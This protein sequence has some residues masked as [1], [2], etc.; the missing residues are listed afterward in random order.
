MP[1]HVSLSAQLHT[2][3]L[4]HQSP[5]LATSVF[6]PLQASMYGQSVAR[7]NYHHKKQP[8]P[9]CVSVCVCV[10]VSVPGEGFG[11][12]A[13]AQ[14]RCPSRPQLTL[15]Q[16]VGWRQLQV[17]LLLQYRICAGRGRRRVL[18]HCTTLHHHCP[19]CKHM[20]PCFNT[21]THIHTYIHT[22]TEW[23]NDMCA[24]THT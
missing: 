1:F 8:Q 14:H 10:C 16:P 11:P 5:S 24:G 20:Q 2:S 3:A 15:S 4:A 9:T 22:H 23:Q 19:L 13:G 6:R 17:R 21:H 18:H 12:A 7:L